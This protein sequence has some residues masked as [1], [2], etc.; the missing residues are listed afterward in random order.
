MVKNGK[1]NFAKPEKLRNPNWV[2]KS[3]KAT[4][5]HMGD[6]ENTGKPRKTPKNPKNPQK[7]R[8]VPKTPDLGSD[9]GIWE[10]PGNPQI[11]EPGIRKSAEK[12][13]PRNA[14]FGFFFAFWGAV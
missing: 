7:P 9:P 11:W 5:R 12:C 14:N 1:I 4:S 2:R 10:I 3:R 8:K 13:Q 6:P